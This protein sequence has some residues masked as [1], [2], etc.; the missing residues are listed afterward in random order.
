MATA[1]ER[2]SETEEMAECF[3]SSHP[4]AVQACREAHALIGE[5]LDMIPPGTLDPESGAWAQRALSWRRRH[6]WAASTE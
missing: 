6:G 2:E 1:T 4:P 3:D 5:A